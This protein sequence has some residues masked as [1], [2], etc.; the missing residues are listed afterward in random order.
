MRKNEKYLE[1]QNK[2]L[3]TEERVGTKQINRDSEGT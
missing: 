3:E 1:S 2:R